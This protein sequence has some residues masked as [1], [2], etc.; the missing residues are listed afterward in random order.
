MLH[1]ILAASGYPYLFYMVILGHI[2]GGYNCSFMVDSLV[3]ALERCL[4]EW[5]IA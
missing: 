1:L 3:S 5:R 4:A 2:F